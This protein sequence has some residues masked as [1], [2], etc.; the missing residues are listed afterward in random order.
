MDA[1]RFDGRFFERFYYARRTRVAAPLDYLPRARLLAAYA[2]LFQIKVRRVLDAGAGAG[3]FLRALE[4][5]FPVARCTGIEVSNYACARYAWTKSSI[6]D[7]VARTPF[8]VV[9][10]HDVLQYLDREA[11]VRALS[12]LATLSKGLLYFTVLT[13]EDWRT[14][15]DQ[16]RTDG[17]VHLRSANWYRQHLRRGF[18]RLGTG[19]YL[20]RGVAPALFAL[21]QAP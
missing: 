1:E 19:V 3:F 16:A 2:S 8:D 12:N 9:V 6:T 11:A 18:L 5:A 15:C 21:D 4:A 20:A 17:K 13:R 14:N 10:C 7:Y